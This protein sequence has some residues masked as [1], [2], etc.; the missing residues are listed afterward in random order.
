MDEVHHV[1][2][3]HAVA[4]EPEP[5]GDPR[6]QPLGVDG[7][8]I[9][10]ILA[11]VGHG[12]DDA[13]THSHAHIGLENI[14]I[15]R[16]EH[17][18]GFELLVGEGA[19][20]GRLPG[21]TEH[22]GHQRVGRKCCQV[23]RFDAPAERMLPGHQNDPVPVIDRQQREVGEHALGAACDGE[24]HLLV[25]YQF[26]NLLGGPLV[27]LQ[28]HARIA[29]SKCLDDLRQNVPRLCVSG[30]DGKRAFLLRGE[31]AGETG[32]VVHLAQDLAGP[33]D[34]L[35]P[36]RRDRSEALALAREQLHAELGLQLFQLLA[37][38]GL[39]G[40]QALR[41]GRDVQSTVGDSNQILELFQ[42]HRSSMQMSAWYRD[43]KANRKI[44][45]LPVIS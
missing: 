28:V 9:V 20:E 4:G 24:I 36:G 34:D 33:F 38:P 42:G 11:L 22:V 21:Q 26:G 45:H 13:D 29:A 14:G 27:Q 39:A 16:G 15:A 19:L 25:G 43:S 32:D 5:G 44:K 18:A 31:I 7:L 6:E 10:L 41:S 12:G 17:D 3:Q 35:M 2:S 23:Q 8:E 40:I 1:A 30:G 37:D